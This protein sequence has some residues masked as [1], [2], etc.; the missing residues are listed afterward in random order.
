MGS[1]VVFCVSYRLLGRVK[2]LSPFGTTA[3]AGPK[4][5]RR[6]PALHQIGAV[7]YIMI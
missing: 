7:I 6:N 1:S 3:A 5:L 2:V 4:L